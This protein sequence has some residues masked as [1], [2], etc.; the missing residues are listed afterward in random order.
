VLYRSLAEI[1]GAQCEEIPF[2]T[3]WQLPGD[4]ATRDARLFFLPNPNSPSGTR[5]EADRVRELAR[6]LEGKSPL[7]IDEAY[8]D[9][10]DANCL[11]LVREF[12]NVIITRSLSKSYSLAGIRYG[13]A[14]ARPELIDGMIKVKD[15]YNCDAIATAAAIAALDD[16]DH[17]AENM[18]RVKSTRRRLTDACREL[19]FLVPESQANFV[20]CTAGPAPALRLFQELKARRILVRYMNYSGYGDGL[21]VSIGTE[22]EID[23][24]L[25][26]L[27]KLV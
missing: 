5:L 13:F 17:F 25:S 21:R 18:A 20:W 16:Q 10:A 12:D 14:V 27:R 1:Q 6:S 8:A 7:V 11:E 22:Q 9:F 15:S 2:G 23:R 4:F 24:F 26:E 19:G 3:D